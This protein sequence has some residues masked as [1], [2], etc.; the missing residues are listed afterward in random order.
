[1]Q[2]NP[3]LSPSGDRVALDITSLKENNLDIWIQDVNKSTS[4][5]VTFA[6]AEETDPVFSR[7]ASKIAFRS[8][9]RGS[10]LFVQKTYG[11][12]PGTNV[13][14]IGSGNAGQALSEEY[15]L[16]PNSW[17]PDNQ[18]ILCSL[19]SASAGSRLLL[20][21][22]ADGKSRPFLNTQSSETNGMISPDGRWAAYAS[23]ESGDW[24]VYVTMFP[25]GTG[26]WQVS[27]SGGTEPRWRQDGKEL[28]Y[29]SPTGMLIAVSLDSREGFSSG[30]TSCTVSGAWT[31]ADLIH[32]PFYLR[33]ALNGNR[34]L[35]NEYVKPAQVTPLTI[36]QH[37][38]AGETREC[39]KNRGEK[40]WRALRDSN[41]RPTDS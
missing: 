35:V 13:A 32:R 15:D 7:D 34:F 11:V 36:V 1:M 21:S 18:Q 3:S 29:L 23:N 27:R 10:S 41:S 16:I 22:V 28:Y 39:G 24:E 20:I 30:H 12:E 37:A 9:V 6:P 25:A 26:K 33:R 2:A 38:L 8:N 4:T 19:Q 17:S 14:K 31:S 40:Q 5:R